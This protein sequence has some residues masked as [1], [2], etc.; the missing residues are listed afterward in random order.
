MTLRSDGRKG[1]I[2]TFVFGPS[3]LTR[4]ALLAATSMHARIRVVAT[5]SKRR[6]KQLSDI[7]MIAKFVMDVAVNLKIMLSY[8]LLAGTLMI[9]P[10]QISHAK[11]LAT[12]TVKM[13]TLENSVPYASMTIPAN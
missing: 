12:A 10:T 13:A 1:L 8:V 3:Y 6:M 2:V 5:I 9:A 11:S 7:R 4:F